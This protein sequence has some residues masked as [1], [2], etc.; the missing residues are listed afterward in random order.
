MKLPEGMQIDLG[1]IAKGWIVQQVA[2]Q[3]RSDHAAAAVSA[4]GDMYF[5]GLP[6]SGERWRVE[7]EDPREPQKT[8]AVLRVGEG[9]V[10]TS[11]VSKR[12]WNQAG[13]AR[14]HIIDPR[15]GEPAQTQWL[16][17]TVVAPRADLA[18]A[19]AK[20]FL[21]GGEAGARRLMIQRPRLALIAVEQDGRLMA[22]PNAKEYL[23]G[24]DQHLTSK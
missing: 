18:E 5:S 7:I 20:A 4:G 12:T 6:A 1:G 2:Q 15:S 19:Y 13:L 11:S 23:N 14:H 9:A 16:S 10:V 17:A 22:S 3:L 21:I 24:S 8:A